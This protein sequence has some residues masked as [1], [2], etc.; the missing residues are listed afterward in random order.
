M[1]NIIR[2]ICVVPAS[3][4]G[5][6]IAMIGGLAALM[7]A[8]SF[9]PADAVVS[10]MCTADYMRQIEKILLLVFPGIAAILVVLLPTLAAPA[11]KVTVAISFF[12][13]GGAAA[14]Y[15]GATLREWTILAFTLACG[16]VTAWSIHAHQRKSAQRLTR[17]ASPRDRD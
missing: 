4:L 5:Y 1:I 7:F 17:S 15:L 14:I 6:Y 13:V 16:G 10:G 8:E 12:I 11:K 9:C 3:Y 2:W